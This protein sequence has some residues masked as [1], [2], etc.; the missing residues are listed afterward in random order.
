VIKGEIQNQEHTVMS[1]GSLNEGRVKYWL[2]AAAVLA[3]PVRKALYELAP[4]GPVAW[5]VGEDAEAVS[6][7]VTPDV[8]RRS[9]PGLNV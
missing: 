5:D 8:S 3:L 9:S 4:N 1:F 2:L 7:P 6:A